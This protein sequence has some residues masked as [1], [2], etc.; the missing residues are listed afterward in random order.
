MLPSGQSI[1]PFSSTTSAAGPQILE[2]QIGDRLGEEG[3]VA[4]RGSH[5]GD[6]LRADGS[7]D[8]AA[9]RACS[10]R[11]PKNLVIPVHGEGDDPYGGMALPY[12]GSRVDT[13]HVRHREIHDD[14]IRL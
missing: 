11:L 2:E 10:H 1:V 13:A 3:P 6:Q 9:N 5:R 8:D 14:D 4:G 7:L 12:P